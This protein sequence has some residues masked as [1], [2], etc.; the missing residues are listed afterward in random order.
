MQ[1]L[2]SRRVLLILCSYMEC[3]NLGCCISKRPC[4]KELSHY[5]A[6]SIIKFMNRLFLN[7][8]KQQMKNYNVE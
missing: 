8:L 3:K 7:K 6:V 1:G 5:F 2:I 4:N